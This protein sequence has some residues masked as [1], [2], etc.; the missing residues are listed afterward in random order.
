MT[1]GSWLD[2]AG[3]TPARSFVLPLDGDWS[4]G[5]GIRVVPS[6]LNV[7]AGDRVA[8]GRQIGAVGNT[9]QSTGPH[10]HFEVHLNGFPVDRQKYRSNGVSA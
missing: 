6:S 1:V 4:S 3:V 2:P 8:A 9:G 5:F 7:V 10:L